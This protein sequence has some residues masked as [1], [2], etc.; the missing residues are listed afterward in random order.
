MASRKGDLPVGARTSTASLWRPRFHPA[1]LWSLGFTSAAFLAAYYVGYISHLPQMD[2]RVY[3]MGGQH[4]FGSSL[5][6]SEI[7]ILGKHLLFTYPPAAAALFWPVSH[8]S[9][10]AGQTIWDVTNLLAL[11]SLIAVSISAAQSRTVVRSDWRT[12]LILLAPVGFLLYPVRSD[13]IIGQINIVL[14]LMIVTDLTVGVSWRG[15]QLPEGA[16]N[17]LLPPGWGATLRHLSRRGEPPDKRPADGG[18]LV[19]DEGLSAVHD[20]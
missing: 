10:F 7:T 1:T 8:Y 6:S 13:L 16:P 2:F 14:V 20:G 12:A 17:C 15:R 18:V 9:D 5:Y 11:T 3:R 19:L 4:V